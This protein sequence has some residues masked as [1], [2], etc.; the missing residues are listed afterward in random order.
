MADTIDWGSTP[1]IRLGDL[2][3]EDLGLAGNL[4]DGFRLEVQDG[5]YS[6]YGYM[7]GMSAKGTLYGPDG[8]KVASGYI[9]NNVFSSMVLKAGVYR[10]RIDSA[11][12]GATAGS[13]SLALYGREYMLANN[14]DDSPGILGVNYQVTV[15]DTAIPVIATDWVGFGDGY[16]F[17]QLNLDYAA[18]LTFDVSS[19]GSVKYTIYSID[20][21][22]LK[23]IKVLALKAGEFKSIKDLLLPAGNYYISMQSTDAQKGGA[24][25]YSVN[26]NEYNCVFY[27]K[28]NNADD[29]F[30]SLGT[31]YQIT[32]GAQ[33]E[34]LLTDEWVGYGDQTDCRQINMTYAGKCTFDFF[35]SDA[36]RFTIYTFSDNKL[37]KL[38][39]VTV[40]PGNIA[41][42]KNLL[43]DAGTYFI[44]VESTNAR[45]GGSAD[46]FVNLNS[47]SAI[48]YQADKTDDLYAN[49]KTLDQNTIV[50]DWVGYSDLIDFKTFALD[51]EGICNLAVTNVSDKLKLTIYV[52]NNG[53][54]KSVKSL[55]IAKGSG[56]IKNLKLADGT[57]YL[58]IESIT[59][60]NGGMSDYQLNLAIT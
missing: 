41:N 4:S 30:G 24:A 52:E 49:A 35:A 11:D 17:R 21:G 60:K 46:Y 51:A 20:S 7:N 43:L 27:A 53:K 33:P 15:H 2:V 42:I 5:V 38:K 6:L 23:P 44:S 8:K 13:Y 45:K 1:V 59:G 22:K 9:N 25:D 10:F 28:G 12:K 58:A 40:K 16:D 3:N 29:S 32:I 14:A 47:S 36:A 18:K 31:A 50:N 56:M 19:S 55:S 39:T 34:P 57:Y 37:R 26:L 48:F 54:L